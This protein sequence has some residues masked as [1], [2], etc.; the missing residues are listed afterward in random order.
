[1]HREIYIEKENWNQLSLSNKFLSLVLLP[2]LI[3]YYLSKSYND[4][5]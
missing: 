4:E 3:L 5:G 2:L 1:M